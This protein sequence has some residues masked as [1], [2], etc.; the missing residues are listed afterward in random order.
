MTQMKMVLVT[1]LELILAGMIGSAVYMT[2]RN[3]NRRRERRRTIP[4]PDN[5]LPRRGQ[6]MT[7]VCSLCGKTSDKPEFPASAIG[8]SRS[9][10]L[11]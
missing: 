6:R 5:H 3:Y 9:D 7:N 11:P 10:C 2:V 4:D 1:V 8:C